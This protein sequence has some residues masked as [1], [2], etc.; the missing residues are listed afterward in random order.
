MNNTLENKV[1]IV[2]GA[3]KG[4][5]LAIA[6]R[7]SESGAH[8]VLADIDAELAA[9]AAASLPNATGVGCDVTDEAQVAAL[10]ATTVETHGHLDVMVNNAGVVGVAPVTTMS[11]SEW[12]RV[13]AVN[14][15]GVFLGV[16]YAGQAMAA[17]AGGSI[18][19]VASIKAF[20][21]L[22]TVS[23]YCASK[24]AVVSLTKSAAL[25]LR[26]HGIRVNAICPGYFATNMITDNVGEME[27]ATGIDLGH[28]IEHLQGR[29]GSPQEVTGL[30][31]FLASDRS[32][33]AN[34]SAYVVDGGAI[35]SIL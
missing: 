21:G 4:L 13:F 14:L 33:M 2:T 24:A 31:V 34:G 3:A 18:I 5:G 1:T 9:K 8:V 29:F 6:E 15:D 35:A 11:L 19:N 10:V 23:S 28:Y 22:P 26:D 27:K 16:K 32:R 17:G 12:R 7:F 25:E 30:A 20:G